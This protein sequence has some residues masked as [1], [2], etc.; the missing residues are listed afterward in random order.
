MFKKNIIIEGNIGTGKTTLGKKLSELYPDSEFIPEPVDKWISLR[1]DGDNKNILENFYVNKNRWSYSFQTYAFLTRSK[2]IL[3]KQTKN[4][5]FLERSILTDRNVFAKALYESGDMTNLEWKMY[6]EWSSWL[7]DDIIGRIGKPAGIIYIRCDPQV[8]FDRVKLRSRSE[9]SSIPLEYLE[10]IHKY[11]DDWL[12]K[13]ELNENVLVIDV[14]K[15]FEN[16]KEHLDSII[17]KIKTF[18][19]DINQ[20][21]KITSAELA[22]ELANEQYI[23]CNI[24]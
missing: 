12:L 9:E 16:D 17:E 2:L 3:E 24:N 8:S 21:S 6:N 13:N 7:Y 20:K 1:D 18:V 4:I 14:N 19:D 5:R 15:D 10:K 23:G 11:H 22:N